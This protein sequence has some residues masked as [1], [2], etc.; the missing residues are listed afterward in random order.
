MAVSTIS[1]SAQ[2]AKKKVDFERNPVWIDMM[3]D[4]T[5]NFYETVEAFREYFKDRPLPKEPFETEEGDVFEKEIGLEEEW[6]EGNK[7]EKEKERERERELRK[8]NT[9]EPSYAAE[10]R[11]FKGWYF[12]S[13]LWLRENG[14]VIGP[15]ERQSIV[16]R[17]QEELRAIEKANGKK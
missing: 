10:V 9:K 16:D 7:S 6:E 15:M 11:A 4:T 1:S 8:R 13:K 12:E 14:T 17:Q 3:N 5:A 2:T